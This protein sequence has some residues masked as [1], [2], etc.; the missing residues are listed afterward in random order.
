MFSKPTLI[1]LINHPAMQKCLE[2][3]GGGK[4]W[5][6]LVEGIDGVDL[7]LDSMALGSAYP[8]SKRDD[9]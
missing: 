1:N 3:G 2:D 7:L 9:F 6:C 5:K 8:H 4:G